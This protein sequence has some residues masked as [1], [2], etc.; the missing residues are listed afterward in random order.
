MGVK[1]FT[2]ACLIASL[3]LFLAFAALLAGHPAPSAPKP[4]KQQWAERF[5][6]YGVCEVVTLVAAGAGSVV[7]VKR[8]RREY[9]ELAM[10]NMRD[11]VEAARKE[12]RG[13]TE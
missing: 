2:S 11:L 12:S 1:V 13:I 6:V 3:A 9:R 7:I 5:L 8:A 4:V 10:A